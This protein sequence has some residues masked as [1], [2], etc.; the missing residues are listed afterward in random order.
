M[1]FKN[2]DLLNL[3]LS[4]GKVENQSKDEILGVYYDTAINKPERF[5]MTLNLVL[6]TF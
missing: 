3:L 4:V 2:A 6:R 1:T 5:T